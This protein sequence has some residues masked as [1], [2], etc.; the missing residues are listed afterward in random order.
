MS[1]SLLAILLRAERQAQRDA[2]FSR[3]WYRRT[4]MTPFQIRYYGDRRN[5]PDA[6]QLVSLNGT[7]PYSCFPLL[8]LN[9]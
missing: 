8:S 3:R 1:A 6:C 2:A 5:W 4:G 7:G 9:P